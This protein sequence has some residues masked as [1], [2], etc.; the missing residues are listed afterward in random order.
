MSRDERQ[1]AMWQRTAP[2]YDA[3]MARLDRRFMAESR[4]WICHRAHGDVL[5]VAIGTGLSLPHYP[6]DVRL[7]ALE[8]SPAMVQ[9]ARS[10][11]EAE[12]V[13]VAFEVGDVH[14]VPFPKE[15]F[16]AVVCAF[17]LCGVQDLSAAVAAMV[18]VLRPG[19]DLLL[20]DHI[21]SSNPVLR[22]G[23]YLMNAVTVPSQNEHWTRRPLRTV[24]DLGMDIV[25]T[26]RLH[27]GI[28]ER[29]HA[30]KG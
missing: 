8:R 4:A 11:A 9:Q 6:A 2:V 18:G 20:A 23:Q 7:T 5:E 28:I 12:Q 26:D 10:R 29:I 30:R 22:A 1:Q 14:A 19:G 13:A 15:S 3:S 16:D 24:R 21:G 27:H 17:A 25:A